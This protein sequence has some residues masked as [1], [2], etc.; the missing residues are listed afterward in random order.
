MMVADISPAQVDLD[1]PL[2]AEAGY[3]SVVNHRPRG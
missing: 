3:E 1:A 2:W